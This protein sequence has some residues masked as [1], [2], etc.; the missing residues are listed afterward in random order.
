V[1]DDL[2]ADGPGNDFCP[3]TREAKEAIFKEFHEKLNPGQLAAF[4]RIVK[5]FNP[6]H[7]SDTPPEVFKRFFVE[8]E[9]G[10]GKY[11]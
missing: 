5:S 10:T 1:V 8:G 3:L 9:G 11:F 4:D 6:S 2:R 7:K